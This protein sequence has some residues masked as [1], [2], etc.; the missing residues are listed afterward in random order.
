MNA[1][2]IL[3]YHQLKKTSPRIV[4]I[5]ALLANDLPMSEIDIKNE[6]GE[7]YDRVTFYRTAQTL[8]KAGIMHRIV[9]DNK[10]I[11]YALNNCEKEHQHKVDH[12]HFFCIDCNK[13]VCLIDTKNQHYP[14]P[15]G[16]VE[17]DCNVIVKGTCNNC[18]KI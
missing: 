16:F 9:V 12:I 14:L 5:Q 8:L 17:H 11:K 1:S 10:I 15:E 6:M 7:L 3:E 2:K 18:N 4:F 13:I